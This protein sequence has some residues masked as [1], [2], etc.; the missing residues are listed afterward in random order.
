[1]ISFIPVALVSMGAFDLVVPKVCDKRILKK[2]NKYIENYEANIEELNYR[3]KNNSEFLENL[4]A[5]DI[6][7]C[8]SE[9]E[10]VKKKQDI[11]E[12]EEMI[13]ALNQKKEDFEKGKKRFEE[14]AAKLEVKFSK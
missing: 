5:L 13:K 8:C 1:M 11:F 6:D 4:K 10:L 7:K 2:Y 9:E 14:L 3:I 12:L